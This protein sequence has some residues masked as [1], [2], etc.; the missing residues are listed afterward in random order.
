M[1]HEKRYTHTQICYLQLKCTAFLQVH[2]KGCNGRLLCNEKI[3]KLILNQ[4]FV[5]ST[6]LQ[7]LKRI[8]NEVQ[9]SLKLDT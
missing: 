2:L 1:Q 9:C 3:E 7:K 6:S 4:C 5:I 8:W